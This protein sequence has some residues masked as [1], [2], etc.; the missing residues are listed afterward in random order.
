MRDHQQTY[1]IGAGPEFNKGILQ[2]EDFES[3]VTFV[4]AGT[5]ADWY[6]TVQPTAKFHGANG[7]ETLTRAT[8]TA[9][10]D[11]VSWQ[12][13]IAYPK[14]KRITVGIRIGAP[15]VSDTNRILFVVYLK[16][17]TR[18]YIIGLWIGFATPSLQYYN[19]AAGWTEITGYAFAYSDNFRSTLEL[20]MDIELGQY[21]DVFWRGKRTSLAGL[22]YNNSAA[23]TERSLVIKATQ[24]NNGAN[25]SCV[26]YDDFYVGEYNKL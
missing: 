25:I 19:S 7:L 18:Y 13:Q 23:V 1:K 20:S 15:D 11:L 5:G 22:A 10:G 24:Y 26:N 4:E 16:N 8:D 3:E 9:N 14:S 2:L 17:G 6:V 21:I 12:K